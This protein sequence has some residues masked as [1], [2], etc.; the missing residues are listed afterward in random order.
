MSL[1]MKQ[2]QTHRHRERT[3]RQNNHEAG[4]HCSVLCSVIQSCPTPCDP[5]DCSPPGSLV[6][7]ISQARILE[8]IATSFS[9]GSSQ[10]RDPTQVSCVS[11][12]SSRILHHCVH[13]GS[14]EQFYYRFFFFFF[15]LKIEFVHI[16]LNGC[17]GASNIQGIQSLP[18][19][20]KSD[21]M[22]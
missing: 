17:W 11:C 18:D 8:W 19:M 14:P 22:V 13:L 1:S 12:I 3:C 16:F 20:F 10:S 7:E 15:L 9:R 5:M 6:P 21:V 2:K 4:R